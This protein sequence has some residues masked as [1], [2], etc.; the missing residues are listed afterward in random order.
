MPLVGR[1]RRRPGRR[2]RRQRRSN[3][4]RIRWQRASGSARRS[5]LNL[6]LA[7]ASRSAS[8]AASTASGWRETGVHA[9][10]RP[11][12][13]GVDVDGLGGNRSRGLTLPRDT[14]EDAPEHVFTPTLTYARQR[15]VIR[16]RLV[17]GVA[18]EP[19][20]IARLTWASRINRRS[21]TMPSR[22][23]PS[24]RRTAA[25]GPGWPLSAR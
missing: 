13:T 12:Q 18:D 4:L 22:K 2:R 3:R 5:F 7:R 24:I 16:Q 1:A 20:R 8:W 11:D 23:P 17:Q 21:S 19:Q 10:I 14:R 25:S 15:R 6:P 9:D